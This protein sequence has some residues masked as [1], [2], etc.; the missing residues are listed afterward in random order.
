M[1][2][3]IVLK[4][5]VSKVKVAYV[6]PVDRYYCLPENGYPIL[7]PTDITPT[8]FDTSSVKYITKEFYEKNKK[9]QLKYGDVIIS[10]CGKDG[11]P[12][13]YKS[14]EKAQMLNAVIIEPDFSKCSPEALCLLLQS[15]MIQKQIQNL[16]S[17]SVQ[18]VINTESIAKLKLPEID[19]SHLEIMSNVIDNIDS[20]I[21]YNN[22]INSELES[23]AKTIYDYW[24]L[25]FEFP[26]EEGKPYKSSGG[27]MVWSEE[28]KR[29]IPEGW[30]VGTLK[31]LFVIKN[32]KDHKQLK[33]GSIPVYGS[34]GIIRYVDKLLFEGE[35]VLIPRKGTLN[36]IIYTNK[37]IW[38]VDTMFY[39]QFLNKHSAIYTYL[40]LRLIDFERLNTGT[41][42]P[43][44]TADIIYNR[45]ILIPPCGVL[46]KFDNISQ[47]SFQLI[48]Q[49][50]NEN[51]GL[52]SLRNFLLP[53]LMNG[54]VTFKDK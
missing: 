16:T 33:D 21:K 15:P 43:S 2:S 49:K 1:N 50:E 30:R 9:S 44:M 53:M 6:G 35:S 4:S 42:V 13:I 5:I 12:V 45:K 36:N 54:Q 8:G 29:E 52:S 48:F 20:K 40:S 23:L 46:K 27:K 22:Q 14:K 28:L 10:R 41:G 31:D 37:A 32:G 51:E 24:F 18:G 47:K 26:N 11:V 39:T 7:R 34:G 25:Q 17:G 38:T 3:Q 19:I